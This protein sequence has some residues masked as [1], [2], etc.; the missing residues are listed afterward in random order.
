MKEI[1]DLYDRTKVIE[2]PRWPQFLIVI[3][4]FKLRITHALFDQN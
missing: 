4:L 2:Y 3:K 1:S